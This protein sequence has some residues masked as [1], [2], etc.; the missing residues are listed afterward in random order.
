MYCHIAYF[1]PTNNIL[2]VRYGN[3]YLA[4]TVHVHVVF[5]LLK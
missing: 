2:E 3:F 5:R 4:A 1:E